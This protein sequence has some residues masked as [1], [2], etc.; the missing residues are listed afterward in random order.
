VWGPERVGYRVNPYF[1][2]FSMSDSNPIGTFTYL[3]RE[4]NRLGLGY[5]HVTEGAVARPGTQRITPLL[6]ESF[7]GALIV[8]GGYDARTGNEAIARG[9]AD[10]VAYGMPY[11]AN[12][13]LLERFKI[14]GPLNKPDTATFYTGEEKGY[15]DYPALAAN[16]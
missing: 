16:S 13:D 10:L 15:V 7:E 5:L 3:A 8:N 2:M 12:P 4:L 14:G 11:L 6:R 1:S 9:E